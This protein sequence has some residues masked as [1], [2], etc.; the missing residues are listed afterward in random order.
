MAKVNTLITERLKKGG[1][2][3][4]MTSMAENSLN[5]HL[6]QFHGMFNVTD[7]S[8]HEKDKLIEI[9]KAYAGKNRDIESD[10]NELI[11][12]TSEVKAINNQ[13]ALLHG[14]RIKKVHTLLTHY[15]EGAFTAWLIHTY[16][17]RQTP[18]N[19][20]QYYEFHEALPRDLRVKIDEM[21]RQAIYTLASRDGDFD[22]KLEIIENYQGE[23]KLAL[24]QLIRDTFPLKEQD[25]RRQNLAESAMVGLRKVHW[26]L[27]R[28]KHLSSAQK[29]E[30]KELLQELKTSIDQ[31]R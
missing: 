26:I 3:S 28:I 27:S 15:K 4:K 9:L 17:N 19:L 29:T 2:S 10:W 1:S 8:A 7:L 16:G 31:K 24:L 20:M 22:K 14:E 21:P 30:L 18:Y 12:V 6:S 25:S 11:K 13:A 5:G 23:T